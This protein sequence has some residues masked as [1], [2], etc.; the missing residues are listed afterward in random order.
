MAGVLA[1]PFV[2]YMGEDEVDPIIRR[3][4]ERDGWEIDFPIPVELFDD[5]E[6]RSGIVLAT[7]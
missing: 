5:I 1:L 3:L 4:R 2:P 7:N 6:R